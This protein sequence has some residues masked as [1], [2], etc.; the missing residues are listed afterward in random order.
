MLDVGQP[1]NYMN[2]AEYNVWFKQAYDQ[3][4]SLYKTLGIETK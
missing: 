1:V 2:A 4:G 3:F